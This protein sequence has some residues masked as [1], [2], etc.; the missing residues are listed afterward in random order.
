MNAA[1]HVTDAA[2]VTRNASLV[3]ILNIDRSQNHKGLVK[4]WT[5]S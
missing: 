4:T 3:N 2:I 1:M 5:L